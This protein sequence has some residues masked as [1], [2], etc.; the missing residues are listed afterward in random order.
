M[1]TMLTHAETTARDAVRSYALALL[2]F[3]AA[4]IARILLDYVVPER[5]PFITFF[6]AVL[7]AAYYCGLAPSVLVLVLSAIVGTIWSDPTGASTTVFYVASFLLFVGLSGVNIALVHYL[8]TTLVRLRQQ[9]Q[10]LSMD[11]SRAQA[12]HQEPLLDR[13]L[14]LPANDQARK[15]CRR[16]VE[17]GDRAHHGHSRGSGLA[18][19]DGIRRRGLA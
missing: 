4:I 6:P 15:I 8:M 13:Q 14:D 16:N 9:D 5:L 1:E 19:R 3:A 11:Q 10:Q 12:P 2:I 18:D 7:L 17:G